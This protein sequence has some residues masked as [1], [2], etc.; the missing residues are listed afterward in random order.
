MIPISQIWNPIN[1]EES[2]EKNKLRMTHIYSEKS[3]QAKHFN[4]LDS[5]SQIMAGSKQEESRHLLSGVT[6]ERTS[7]P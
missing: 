1:K 7:N 4:F 3:I 5:S 2:G 6:S